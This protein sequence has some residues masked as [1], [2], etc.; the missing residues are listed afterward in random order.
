MSGDALAKHLE[1]RH[2][3]FAVDVEVGGGGLPVSI[4]ERGAAE[5]GH[6]IV[7]LEHVAEHGV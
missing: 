1:G 4:D 6:A 2:S 7:G 3:L 5:F